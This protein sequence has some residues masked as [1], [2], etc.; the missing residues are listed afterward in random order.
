M[1][2]KKENSSVAE[3]LIEGM[4][5]VLLYT[6][7][8]IQLKTYEL[9]IPDEPTPDS[10]EVTQIRENLNASIPAFAHAMN[11]TPATIKK[12]ESGKA[13]PSG[14][15]VR[16]LHLYR[17]EPRLLPHAIATTRNSS[18]QGTKKDDKWK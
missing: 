15:A 10:A 18:A 13:R 11:V 12:W 8:K 2:S 16:L 1:K 7:G 6:Q 14:P 5:E 9:E 4:K 3:M 17:R